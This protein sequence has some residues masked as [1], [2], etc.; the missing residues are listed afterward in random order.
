MVLHCRKKK[1]LR[2]NLNKVGINLDY[3]K[4]AIKQLNVELNVEAYCFTRV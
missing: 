2:Q 3:I 4:K 1:K